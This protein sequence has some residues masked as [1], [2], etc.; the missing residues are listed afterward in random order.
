MR[1]R[2]MH[3]IGGLLLAGA[4]LLGLSACGDNGPGK[5]SGGDAAEEQLARGY[6]DFTRLSGRTTGSASVGKE[7]AVF[8]SSARTPSLTLGD[9]S[10]DITG[11]N[12][13]K[14]LLKNTSDLDTLTFTFL[15]ASDTQP[16]GGKTVAIPLTKTEDFQEVLVDMSEVY[17][18]LFTLTEIGLETAAPASGEL[19]IRSLEVCKGESSFPLSLAPP[20]PYLTFQQRSAKGIAHY[21][22]GLLGFWKNPEG[23]LLFVGSLMGKLVLS[24]G[25]PE[26]PF[27]TVIYNDR[28]VQN[29]DYAKYPYASIAQVIRV[30]DS[31]IL[32]SPTHLEY[33][34]GNAVFNGVLGLSV[35]TDQ[36]QTWSLLGEI[37]S[38]DLDYQTNWGYSHDIGNGEMY[39]DDEFVYIYAIDHGEN[40]SGLSVSRC[41]TAEFYTAIKENRVPEFHKKFN[42]EWTEPGMGGQFDPIQPAGVGANFAQVVYSTKLDQYL[43]FMTTQF[44]GATEAAIGVYISDDPTDFTQ[45]KGYAVSPSMNGQQYPTVVDAATGSQFEVGDTFYLYY[46]QLGLPWKEIQGDWLLFWGSNVYTRQTISIP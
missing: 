31:D 28:R 12:Q 18:F 13:L 37:I 3:R 22:D 42:G 25:T 32:V 43:L 19:V 35:S 27:A 34:F 11:K 41:P 23:K 39:I 15:T 24:E 16:G 17:G 9:I 33:Q 21:P 38:H 26:D 6:F 36:G 5:E 45:S 4:L 46:G 14:L 29:V 44:P 20:E 8:D 40:Q 1:H 2:W 7:G 30:P 10:A